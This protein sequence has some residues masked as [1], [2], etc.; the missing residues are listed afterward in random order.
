[1][2]EISSLSSAIQIAPT[3]RLAASQS[4]SVE[5]E[6]APLRSNVSNGAQTLAVGPPL[7]ALTPQAAL[8]VQDGGQPAEEDNKR[9]TEAAVEDEKEGAARDDSGGAGPQDLTAPEQALVRQLQQIDADV[10]RHEQAHAAAS[11]GQA[12]PPSFEFTQGPDGKQ[13]ATGGEVSISVPTGGGDPE[14]RIDKLR[15]VQQAALAPANP[16]PQDLRV[17]AS[18][19]QGISQ[20][21][22]ELRLEQATARDADDLSDQVI[23]DVDSA[24]PFEI[25]G[26]DDAQTPPVPASDVTSQQAAQAFQAAAELS[27]GGGAF[28]SVNNTSRTADIIA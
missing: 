28:T 25:D 19:A 16:S 2:I 9:Q 1:M 26:P 15:Q 18:A 3:A 20:A 14:S 22:G 24:S 11:G 27:S 13:Y 21:Q 6:K 12:G 10:R 5:V 17:A 4:V 8:A 23:E 7:N